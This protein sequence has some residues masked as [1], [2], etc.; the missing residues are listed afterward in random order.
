MSCFLQITP[1][2]TVLLSHKEKQEQQI[3]AQRKAI[4]ASLLKMISVAWRVAM[5]QKSIQNLEASDMCG[6]T[7][8]VSRYWPLLILKHQSYFLLLHQVSC[9]S[10]LDPSVTGNVNAN[11]NCTPASQ[12]NIVMSD[13]LSAVWDVIIRVLSKDLGSKD[14]CG[15][16]AS[17]TRISV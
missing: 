10:T 4:S 16:S 9:E 2:L 3:I 1:M 11:D 6:N 17:C 8:T 12:L 13:D 5:E 14:A 15:N 7:S